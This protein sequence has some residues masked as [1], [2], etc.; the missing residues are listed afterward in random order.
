MRALVVLIALVMI[1]AAPAVAQKKTPAEIEGV[2]LDQNL[3]A[4]LPLNTT[5]VTSSGETVRLD[6]LRTGRPVV[7]GLVYYRC[8]MLCNLLLEGLLS[9]IRPLSL[10]VGEDFDIWTVSFDEREG[11]E[12]AARKKKSI[13]DAY[14]REG[15]EQGWHFLT[16][17][18]ASIDAL[19]KAVGFHY[20][21]DEETQQFAHSSAL[22][23]ATPEGRISRYFYGV[24]YQPRDL[25]LGLVEASQNEIGSPV[26]QLLLMCFQYDPATGKYGFVIQGFL[27]GAGILTAA[28]VGGFIGWC[29]WRERR[30]RQA[31]AAH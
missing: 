18:A 24:E 19:C 23:V 2:R 22:I 4:L 6:D 15:A 10:T 27:R 8:P 3:D 9:A 20:Q 25:R 28:A 16:G 14:E 5:F 21:W 7:L 26:D 1:L 12:L 30:A 11:P 17:D 29:L 13:V 31:P